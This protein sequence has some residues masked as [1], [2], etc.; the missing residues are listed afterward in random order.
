MD[1]SLSRLWELVMDREA[2]NAAVYG[3]A[4]SWTW[5][6]NWTELRKGRRIRDQIANISWIIKKAR[7]FQKNIYFFFI[8]YATALAV[9][10]TINSGKFLKR[11][12]HQTTW[13]ICMQVKKQQ[14][15]LYVE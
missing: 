4:K 9:W 6:S 5:L 12:E 10:M 11:W 13:E 1:M 3:I 8:D 7:E 15:E 14:L 2:W